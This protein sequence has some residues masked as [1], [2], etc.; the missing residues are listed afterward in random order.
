MNY[1]LWLNL[2]SLELRIRLRFLA[3]YLNTLLRDLVCVNH[4]TTELGLKVKKIRIY[5]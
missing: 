5:I 2:S 3:M 4:T 1:Y